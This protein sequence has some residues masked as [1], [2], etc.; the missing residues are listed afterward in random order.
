MNKS[1]RDTL[2]LGKNETQQGIFRSIF[3]RPRTKSQIAESLDLSEKTVANNLPQL[4]RVIDLTED[5]QFIRNLNRDGQSIFSIAEKRDIAIKLKPKIHSWVQSTD[6]PYIVINL[7]PPPKGYDHWI[8]MPFGDTHYGADCCD[9]KALNGFIRLVEETPNILVILKGDLIENAT[10]ESPGAGIFQQVIPPQE[11]KERFTQMMA[12]IAHRILY[13]LRGNHGFRSV[14]GA[15]LDPEKDISDS[16]GVPFFRGACYAD[17]VV[18]DGSSDVLKW[19]FFSWHGGG[20]AS[21]PEGRLRLMRKKAEFH[22]ANIYTMGHVHDLIHT[23]DYEVVRDPVNLTLV[24]KKRYYVVCG[25]TMGYWNSYAEEWVLQPN[26]VGFA[27]IRLYC[28]NSKNPGDY[29]VVT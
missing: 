2:V 12:P 26:K 14:K 24:E 22:S 3:N 9:V 21:T 17:I 1:A 7:P 16:L 10:R 11:Q 25:T 8:I 15:Y 18:D 6:R 5:F 20:S 28:N 19:E 13:S 4:K 23:S 27:R 29:D